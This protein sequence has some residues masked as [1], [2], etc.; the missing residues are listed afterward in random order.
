MV[1][2]K[3]II[4][5]LAYLTI[6]SSYLT[7]NSLSKYSYRNNLSS[8]KEIA[9]FEV[10]F[11]SGDN[12]DK[13]SIK[14]DNSL[15]NYYFT[16]KSKSEVFVSYNVIVSNIPDGVNVSIDNGSL[17]TPINGVATFN[18]VGS[19]SASNQYQTREHSLVLS[20]IPQIDDLSDYNIDLDVIFIQD[21]PSL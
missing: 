13:I 8:S 11:E 5:I 1:K 17:V 4:F 9:K 12:P 21:N 18:N 16:V 7:M 3:Y 19:F 15:N 2:K 6:L 10:D 14:A 20:A